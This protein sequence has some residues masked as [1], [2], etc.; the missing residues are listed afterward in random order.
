[1]RLL[2]DEQGGSFVRRESMRKGLSETGMSPKEVKVGMTK[3]KEWVWVWVRV[4]MKS[5]GRD[6]Q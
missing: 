1:M 4:N 5:F 2:E 3:T 6:V